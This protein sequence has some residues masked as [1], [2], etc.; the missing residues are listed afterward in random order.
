MSRL[1]PQLR[2]QN[3]IR[4]IYS[5]LHIEGNH[6]SEDQVSTL[7]EGKKVLGPQKDIL[8]VTNA[9]SLYDL[10]PELDPLSEKHFLVAHKQLMNSLIP[11]AG[12]YR[13]KSVG[14]VKGKK[15]A[16]LAPPPSN[17]PF[18]MRELF[19]WVKKSEE[20]TLIKSCVFHYE[21]EFIHPFIDGNGRMGRLWQTLLLMREYPVF[22][23]LPFENLISRNQKDYYDALAI[24]D[25][26]GASTVFIEYMLRIVDQSLSPYVNGQ[27][28]KLKEKDRLAY[29]L[30]LGQGQFTRSDYIAVFRNISAVT[31]S[32]DL[33]TGVL[34]GV[35]EKTGD[36]RTAT[37]T[38]KKT[39]K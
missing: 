4:T 39:G 6:L 25:K 17:V 15:I 3:R 11:D 29:F 36:K 23:F 9:L 10:L 32:R 21:M 16:H 5:T 30:S 34:K 1:S 28:P 27:A 12:K 38:V 24:S 14:I 26:Q 31:A 7:L 2:K 8:E 18:L 22:E 19:Q 35:I 20:I 37:Y 13:R 33:K